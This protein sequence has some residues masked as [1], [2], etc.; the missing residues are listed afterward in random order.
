MKEYDMPNA[1]SE[2]DPAVDARQTKK[3]VGWRDDR[4]GMNPSSE[5]V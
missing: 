1:V 2:S 4:N 5:A 3:P